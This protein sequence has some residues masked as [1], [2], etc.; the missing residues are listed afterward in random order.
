[1]RLHKGRQ[2]CRSGFACTPAFG[3]EDARCAR[4]LMGQL[5]LAPTGRFVASSRTGSARICGYGADLCPWQE[6]LNAKF[7]KKGAK[8]RH[9]FFTAATLADYGNQLEIRSCS[10]RFAPL[11]LHPQELRSNETSPL[12]APSSM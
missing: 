8:F 12:P 11:D 6:Y 1:M 10:N 5:K 9:G 3:R 2:F 7:A 4:L